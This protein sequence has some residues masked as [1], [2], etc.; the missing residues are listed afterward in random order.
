MKTGIERLRQIVAM[1]NMTNESV[2]DGL[3]VAETVRLAE[4]C[5]NSPY[6]ICPDDLTEEERWRASRTGR[7]PESVASRYED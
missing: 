4:A 3:D 2:F 7:L 6:D 1:C 5:L